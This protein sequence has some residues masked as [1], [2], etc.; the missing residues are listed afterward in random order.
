MANERAD[1]GHACACAA[2]ERAVCYIIHAIEIPSDRT[3]SDFRPASRPEAI[4]AIE[5]EIIIRAK[6]PTRFVTSARALLVIRD[7]PS[8]I[9]HLANVPFCGVTGEGVSGGLYVELSI[10]SG[11]TWTVNPVLDHERSLSR[12]AVYGL[13]LLRMRRI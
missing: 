12:I 7:L 6:Q 1:S 4:D 13:S 2:S 3:R 11:G 9:S 10:T 8:V 5:V